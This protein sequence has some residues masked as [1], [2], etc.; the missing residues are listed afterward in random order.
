M[1]RAAWHAVGDASRCVMEH[2][3]GRVASARFVA[4]SG[5][6]VR[7]E[8]EWQQQGIQG[9]GAELALSPA[10]WQQGEAEPIGNSHWQRQR[11]QYHHDIP[12]VLSAMANGRWLSIREQ[13]S[14][15]RFI[16]PSVHFQQAYG[17]FRLCRGEAAVEPGSD[18]HSLVLHFHAG[19]RDLSAAQQQRLSALAGR[20]ASDRQ[21]TGLVIESF[22]DSSGHPE[23]NQRLSRERGERVA[24]LLRRQLP[25]LR[26]DIKAY[27]EA[28]PLAANDTPAGRYQNRRVVIRIIKQEQAS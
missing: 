9:G 6:G 17:Q 4:D 20:L 26:L 28:S 8:L 2:Q 23:L 3:V 15:R 10:P 21:V 19:V 13:G 11:L 27:G 14:P 12:S 1:D 16:I 24:A 7:F 5:G 22:T 25:A 18:G